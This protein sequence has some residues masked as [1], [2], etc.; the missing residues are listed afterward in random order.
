MTENKLTKNQSM[1]H[2]CLTQENGPMTAYAI[3]DALREKGFRAPLQVYRALEK[4]TEL[5]LVHRLESMS[6]FVACQHGTCKHSG[7]A[8]FAI[9]DSCGTVSEFAAADVSKNLA[10]HLKESGFVLNKTTIELRG[11]CRQCYTS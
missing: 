6:A 10:T 5:K 9:C 11:E 2:A 7:A 8:V 1:V 4:L 3:L